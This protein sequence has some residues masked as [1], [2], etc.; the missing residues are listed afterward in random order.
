MIRNTLENLKKTISI[1]GFLVAI[2]VIGINGQDKTTTNST[3]T[4]AAKKTLSLKDE[5]EDK[6]RKSLK[7][8]PEYIANLSELINK[9]PLSSS[10]QS[11]L[12]SLDR[13]LKDVK[14]ANGSRTLVNLLIKNTEQAP[15]PLKGEIYRR[16]AEALFSRGFY[17]EAATL[18]QKAI[19]LFDDAGY[20]GF[21]KK[22][23]EAAMAELAIKNP[24][25]KPRDFDVERTK[26]FYVGIKSDVYNLLGKSLWEQSKFEQAEKAYRISYAIKK[27]KN[28]ALGIAHAAEKN[29]KDTEALE[30]AATAVLTAGRLDTS[31]TDYFYAL[32]AKQ[33]QSKTDGAEEYLDNLYRNTYVNPVKGEKYKPTAKRSDRTVLVEFVT[34]AGC[35]PCIPVDYTFERALEN[36]SSK[37]VALLVYHWYA[38]TWDPLDNYSSDTRVKYYDVKGAP[39]VFI[40]GVK[41]DNEGDYYGSE[42]EQGEIQ[43][44]AHGINEEIKSALETPAEARLKLKAKRAGQNVSVSVSAD[45]IKNASSDVSLQIALVENEVTYSGENGLRF[46]L[47]VVRGLAGDNEKRDFGFKIDP[48]KANKFEY[49]FDINKII[50]QNASY[51]DTFKVEK[52]KEFA[53][54]FGGQIPDGLKVE[55]KYKKNQINS[56][57]LSVIAFLQDNKT[58]KILQ[59]SVVNL[60]KK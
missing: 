42:G 39:T 49:V 47:N 21:Q 59:S 30:F 51:Y 50:A 53:E 19:D 15:A 55:F 29:G 35:I 52:E 12:Y 4:S 18:S 57:N 6:L 7:T 20:L 8:P 5:L 13:T 38:P 33:H 14:D 45:K 26:G 16:S 23:H 48:T 27:N 60:A 22:Q 3:A 32:Y 17:E 11:Y 56:N 41:S 40:N 25:Y 37:D 1:L 58:K 24:Q 54:R 31:A 28:A 43:E 44:I 34:G 9:Y 2:F 46:H 36:Y 10:I